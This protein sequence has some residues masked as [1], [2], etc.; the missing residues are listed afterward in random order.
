MRP[1]LRSRYLGGQEGSGMQTTQRDEG[2]K[3]QR[4]SGSRARICK[5][6]SPPHSAL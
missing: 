2:R 1:Q 6:S 5:G 4:P 3:V